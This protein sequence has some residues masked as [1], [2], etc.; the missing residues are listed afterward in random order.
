MDQVCSCSSTATIFLSLW[1]ATVTTLLV[2]AK[3]KINCDTERLQVQA[4]RIMASHVHDP[5]A[6]AEKKSQSQC[7]FTAVRGVQSPRFQVLPE[8][9]QG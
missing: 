6:T 1:A 3:H 9:S 8:F 2:L 4:R 5:P 7:T